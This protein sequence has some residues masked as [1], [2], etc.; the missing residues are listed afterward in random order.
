ML[1]TEAEIRAEASNI[2]KYAVLQKTMPYGN[3]TGMTADERTL[4]GQWYTGGQN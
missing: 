3:A 2:Y 4:L 1:D